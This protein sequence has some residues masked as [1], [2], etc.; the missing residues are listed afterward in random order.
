MFAFIW[1]CMV[2]FVKVSLGS[3]FWSF[4]IALVIAVCVL[5]GMGFA[6]IIAKDWQWKGKIGPSIHDRKPDEDPEEWF[7]KQMKDKDDWGNA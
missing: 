3:I 7:E 1:S 5:I 2:L 4:A 6:A